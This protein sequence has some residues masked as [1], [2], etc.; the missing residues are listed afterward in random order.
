M[1]KT[2]YEDLGR[3]FR[4][5]IKPELDPLLAAL[6]GKLPGQGDPF[7]GEARAAWLKM[8]AMAFDVA[9]GTA[10]DMP[11]FLPGTSARFAP[12]AAPLAA[13]KPRGAGHDFR[14][15]E[16]GHALNAEGVPVLR[17]DVPA[18]TMIFDCR[19][20]PNDGFRDIDGITWADGETGTVGLAGGC[21]F[22]GPG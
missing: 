10:E 22:C 12:A 2:L 13:P 11:A 15:D 16:Q 14:I 18:E 21:T 17:S 8:M 19:P 3:D 4:S 1:A 20:I 6:I 9:Y 7:S 5:S